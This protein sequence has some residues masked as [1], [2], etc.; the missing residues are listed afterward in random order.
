MTERVLEEIGLTFDDVLI[1]PRYSEVLPIEVNVT[2]MLLQNPG[3]PL[4]LLKRAGLESSTK[5]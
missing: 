4:L 3:W 2:S 5:I 1:I